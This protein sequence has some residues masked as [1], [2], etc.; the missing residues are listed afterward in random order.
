MAATSTFIPGG[1]P[2]NFS[3]RIWRNRYQKISDDLIISNPYFMAPSPTFKKSFD[4]EIK[5]G[6]AGAKIYYTLDGSIPTVSSALYSKPIPISS[7]T[8][9]KAIA[10]KDGKSSFVDEG[11]FTKIRDDI[12]LTLLIFVKVPSSTK[13]DF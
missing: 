4:L 7:N 3:C 12:K 6:E 11:T 9:V 2:I 10:V 5:C 8:T 13:L 1:W